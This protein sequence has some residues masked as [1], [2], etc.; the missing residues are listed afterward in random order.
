MEGQTHNQVLMKVVEGGGGEGKRGGGLGV[1]EKAS[2]A[3]NHNYSYR[4]CYC[5]S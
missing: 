3:G 2:S 5:C 1:L 4:H